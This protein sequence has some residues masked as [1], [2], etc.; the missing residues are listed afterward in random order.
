MTLWLQ[1]IACAAV[2]FLTATRLS[3]YGDIIAE[4]TGLSAVGQGNF[5]SGS[6]SLTFATPWDRKPQNAYGGHQG[7]KSAFVAGQ[8]RA[9]FRGVRPSF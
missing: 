1:F 7:Q 8:R 9:F 6:F 3:K 2:I 4:K 5:R